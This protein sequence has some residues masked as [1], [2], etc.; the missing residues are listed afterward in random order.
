M[1]NEPHKGIASSSFSFVNV[2]LLVTSRFEISGSK[3]VASLMA[4]LGGPVWGD[5]FDPSWSFLLAKEKA[6][7]QKALDFDHVVV[8]HSSCVQFELA[9][10]LRRTWANSGDRMKPAA[11]GRRLIARAQLFFFDYFGVLD[12]F[13]RKY[14]LP[15]QFTM[16]Y[17]KFISSKF[18][19]WFVPFDPPLIKYI[20]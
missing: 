16:I 15:F 14:T 4:P 10:S 20:L 18:K 9:A 6:E 5:D 2:R 1:C 19:N 3:F 11:G 8:V 13:F 17:L 7:G 12:F